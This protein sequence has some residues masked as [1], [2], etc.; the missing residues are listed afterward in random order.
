MGCESAKIHNFRGLNFVPYRLK[1]STQK[2][3]I[4]F[5]YSTQLELNQV[6]IGVDHNRFEICIISIYDEKQRTELRDSNS[7]LI[8]FIDTILSWK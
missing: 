7:R 5:D 1:N 3:C 2:M 4:K 8:R 6:Q